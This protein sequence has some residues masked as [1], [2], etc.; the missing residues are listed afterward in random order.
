MVDGKIVIRT[1][2]V[3][4][5][6]V[7]KISPT[8]Y[9]EAE[10]ITITAFAAKAVDG[11]MIALNGVDQTIRGRMPNEPARIHIGCPL[12]AHVTNNYSIDVR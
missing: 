8:T 9:N 5:A 6:R 4:T 7:K 11:Q 12:S 10:Q 1:G 2:A 3:A